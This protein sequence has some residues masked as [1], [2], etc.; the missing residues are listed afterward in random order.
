M[1]ELHGTSVVSLR[2]HIQECRVGLCPPKQ[3]QRRLWKTDEVGSPQT[4]MEHN[5]HNTV[6]PHIPPAT[7]YFQVKML[8]LLHLHPS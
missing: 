6:P 4:T 7:Q 5:M 3:I 8:Q 1:H 2:V